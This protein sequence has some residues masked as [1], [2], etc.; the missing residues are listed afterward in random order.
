MPWLVDKTQRQEVSLITLHALRLPL[1]YL[2][3]N[4]PSMRSQ[5]LSENIQVSEQCSLCVYCLMHTHQRAHQQSKE[6]CAFVP[7]LR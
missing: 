4:M 2:L 6:V 5:T 1:R 7:E 3:C